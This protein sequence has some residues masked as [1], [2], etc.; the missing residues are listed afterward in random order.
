MKFKNLKNVFPQGETVDVSQSESDSNYLYLFDGHEYFK[1]PRASLSME[2]ISLLEALYKM[3]EPD[4]MWYQFLINGKP[5]MN[6][7][8]MRYQFIHFKVEN[9]NEQ[10]DFWLK[11]L[12][13]YFE[14][15]EDAFFVDNTSGLIIIQEDDIDRISLEGFIQTLDD[16]F[17]SKTSLY[18][19]M[20]MTLSESMIELYKEELVYFENNQTKDI[21]LDFKNTYIHK[22]VKNEL[23]RS[24]QAKLYLAKI[25]Q[26]EN[27]S[28][29]IEALWAN[30]G[31]ITQTASA[32]Y[33]HRNTLNYRLDKF[34]EETGLSLRVLDDLLL[35]YL[36]IH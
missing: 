29:L 21:V 18:I 17:S 22:I 33:L 34:F 27:Y 23:V 9:L 36:L 15:C 11:T 16:D 32:L 19:G 10:K 3:K 12:S 8:L 7:S 28:A 5:F 30:Q 35:A 6:R 26:Q 13:A 25:E 1:I 31:N 20:A 4:S 2:N 24:E 14:S